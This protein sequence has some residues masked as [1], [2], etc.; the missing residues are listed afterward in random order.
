LHPDEKKAIKDKANGDQA[1]EQR[2]TEAACYRVQCWAQYSPNSDAWAANYV[3]PEQAATLGPEL[4]WVDSQKVPGGPFDYTPF[5]QGKDFVSSQVDMAT[6]GAKNAF[7]DLVGLIK[8]NNGQTAP[9]DADPLAD[10]LNGGTPPPTA[11]SVVTPSEFVNQV[12][13][14]PSTT[15]TNLSRGGVEYRLPNG[16]GIRFNADGSFSG[17]LDPKK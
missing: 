5:Q 1:A 2:L 10:L 6:R 15:K 13:S 4:P 17:F 3:S 12:L 14:D 7:S 11:P 16:Q 9:A 8:G